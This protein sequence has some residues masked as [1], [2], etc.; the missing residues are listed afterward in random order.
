MSRLESGEREK[1][2]AGWLETADR[3]LSAGLFEPA[4]RVVLAPLISQPRA[5]D[6]SRPFRSLTSL[7][8]DREVRVS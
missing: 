8:R 6:C 4:G 2:D 7:A 3:L 5:A 1:R